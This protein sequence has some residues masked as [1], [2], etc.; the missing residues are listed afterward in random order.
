MRYDV[1]IS[2]AGEDK[3]DFVRPLAEALRDHRLEVWFDE[4]SLKVGDGLRQSLDRGLAESAYGIVVLSP[5]FFSKRWPVW[6]L[7]GLVQLHNSGRGNR[8]L[9]IWHGVEHGDVQAFSPSLANIVAISSSRG[10]E[11]VVAGLLQVLRPAGSTLV[12][13]RDVLVEIGYSK[14]PVVTDDWWLDVV[15]ASVSNPVEGT[16]QEG[17]GW[18]RWGFPLPPASSEPSERGYRLGW[19]AAQ[20]LWQEA[21]ESRPITQITPPE[22][23]LAFIEEHPGL[24]ERCEDNL[25]YLLVYA[26]QLAIAGFGGP[27]EDSFEAM[28]SSSSEYR[29]EEYGSIRN[30]ERFPTSA[31]GVAC[32]FIQGPLMGPE[33]RFYETFDYLAW[34]LSNASNWLPDGLRAAL[35]EGMGTWVT[36]PWHR[37][38]LNRLL[39]DG[40]EPIAE[41]GALFDALYAD[42]VTVNL[43]SGSARIDL[44][45]RLAFSVKLLGIN[46]KPAALIERFESSGII[47]AWVAQQARRAEPGKGQ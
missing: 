2:H 17:S 16:F 36:W 18:G 45:H 3:A 40:F 25:S 44:E 33:A 46:D 29:N 19:A 47:Q 14:P 12:I 7:D 4:F 41:T 31:A 35:T 8:V 1:F 27:F 26:P 5:S 24:R 6:E 13:A 39:P 42:E 21:A 23:V 9:P 34:F 37:R 28:L 32:L 43:L 10:L 11:S 22:Q 30:I 15:E 38:E 20:S